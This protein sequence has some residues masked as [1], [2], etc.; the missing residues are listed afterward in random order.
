MQSCC[1]S[2]AFSLL[3]PV[4]PFSQT[5]SVPLPLPLVLRVQSWIQRPVV[6]SDDREQ[7]GAAPSDPQPAAG[8]PNE[9]ASTVPGPATQAA[10]LAQEPSP[11]QGSA[12][13]GEGREGSGQGPAPGEPDTATAASALAAAKAAT[14]LVVDDSNKIEVPCNELA[15]CTFLYNQRCV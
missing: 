1:F 14:A 9:S 10:G 2:G 5:P 15:P 12:L 11:Q 13:G 8:T 3:T 7:P 4:L 6:P